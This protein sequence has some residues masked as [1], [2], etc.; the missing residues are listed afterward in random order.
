MRN[1]E[2]IQLIFFTKII[3]PFT[4]SRDAGGGSTPP[5]LNPALSRLGLL[6]KADYIADLHSPPR[7]SLELRV[8]DKGYHED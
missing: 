5:P 6:C 2:T 8:G 1:N 3:N 7:A 4:I